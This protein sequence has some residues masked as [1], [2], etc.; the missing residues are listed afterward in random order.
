[1]AGLSSSLPVG[2]MPSTKA[3]LAC[4]T[5]DSNARVL[6]HQ[7]NPISPVFSH[8]LPGGWEA[9]P[10]WLLCLPLR[11]SFTQLCA[12]GKGPLALLSAVRFG[13]WDVP[14]EGQRAGGGWGCYFCGIPSGFRAS[15]LLPPYRFRPRGRQLRACI[16]ASL[17][18]PLSPCWFCQICP[19][20][21]KKSLP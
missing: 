9:L 21:Y 11:A 19:Q 20:L 16:T 15:G 4:T 12:P 1:M 17:W 2:W 10:C 18:V 5:T 3:L 7:G 8:V 14:D 13:P 6:G